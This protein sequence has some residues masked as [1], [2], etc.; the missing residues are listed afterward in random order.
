MY[1]MEAW[2]N[3][4]GQFVHIIS[5]LTGQEGDSFTQSI[6]NLGIMGTEYKRNKSVPNYLVYTLS[7][8]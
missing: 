5:D 6:C 1:G 7:K 8:D 2:C 3:L 4:E